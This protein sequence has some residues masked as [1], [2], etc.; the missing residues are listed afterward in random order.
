MSGKNCTTILI[1]NIMA[2]YNQSEHSAPIEEYI[3]EELQ[4]V[5]K[6]EQSIEKLSVD[7]EKAE[8]DYKR[9]KTDFV[10]RLTNIQI[11]CKHYNKEARYCGP[12]ETSSWYVCVTCGKE[13]D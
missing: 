8:S 2:S 3:A 7:T 1:R 10:T 12:P 13:F 5:D 6:I 11:E 9:K 4:G